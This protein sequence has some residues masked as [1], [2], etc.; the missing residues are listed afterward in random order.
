MC[1]TCGCG[2]ADHQHLHLII[3][4]KGMKGNDDAALL[5]AALN[6]LPGVHAT[7]DCQLGAVSLLLHEQGDLASAKDLIREVG[8]EV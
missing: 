5:E 6:G 1:D 4:V 2:S 8:F 3:P 7:A